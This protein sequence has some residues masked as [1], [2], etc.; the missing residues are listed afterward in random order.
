[1]VAAVVERIRVD[2]SFGE[3][4]VFDLVNIVDRYGPAGADGGGTVGPDAPPIDAGT[5]G[6]IERALA[7]ATVVWVASQDEIV[8]GRDELPSYVDVGAVLTVGA[9]VVE[10]DVAEVTTALWCGGLCGIG[11]THTLERRDGGWVVTGSTGAQW[12]S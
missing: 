7:P 4:D 5:R 6:A 12:I 8:G 1:V 3:P 9:P 11:G 10:G 2:N